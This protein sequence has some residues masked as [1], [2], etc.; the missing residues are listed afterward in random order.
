MALIPD[1]HL[2]PD[3]RVSERQAA[4]VVV[5][6]DALVFGFPSPYS[7]WMDQAISVQATLDIKVT[8]AVV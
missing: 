5:Y 3:R 6:V 1:L 2:D 7:G 8:D 4:P